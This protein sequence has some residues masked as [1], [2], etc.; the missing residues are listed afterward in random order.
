HASGNASRLNRDLSGSFGSRKY[1]FEELVALSGQSG[2]E[3]SGQ[4]G[5]TRSEL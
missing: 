2:C 4:S 3:L 1:A 5:A